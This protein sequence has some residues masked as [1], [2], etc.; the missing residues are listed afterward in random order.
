M[1]EDAV[2]LSRHFGNHGYHA[3]G[4]AR[5]STP[6]NGPRAIPR[7][8][9]THGTSIEGGSARSHFRNWPR[10]KFTK[11]DNVDPWAAGPSAYL[12]RSAPLEQPEESYGDHLVVD[13]AIDKL[14]EKRDKPLFLAVGLFRPIPQGGRSKMVRPIPHG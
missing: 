3:A 5:S 14:K 4:E 2:V 13:W 7:T 10:P 12:F 1:L 6:C 11:G 9:P 8:I